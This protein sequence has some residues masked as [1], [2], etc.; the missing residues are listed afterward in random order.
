MD[1]PPKCSKQP[2]FS[3]IYLGVG[4]GF[5]PGQTHL[6]HLTLRYSP[7][8]VQEHW[9]MCGGTCLYEWRSEDNSRESALLPLGSSS[10]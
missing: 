2:I 6:R 7:S 10:D 4:M 1:L 3:T 8:C 5:K 9:P